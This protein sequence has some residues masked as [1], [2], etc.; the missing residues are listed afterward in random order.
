MINDVAI[1]PGCYIHIDNKTLLSL[2]FLNLNKFS[3]ISPTA[4]VNN[5]KLGYNF[6]GTIFSIF[7]FAII[8]NVGQLIREEIWFYRNRFFL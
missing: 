6:R 5:G 2:D 3:V 4:I 7:S 8:L 1:F